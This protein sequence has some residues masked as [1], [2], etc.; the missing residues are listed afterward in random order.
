MLIA[1]WPG[2]TIENV[3]YTC[4]RRAF[5]TYE[6]HNAH[7]EWYVLE[8]RRRMDALI[9]AFFSDDQRALVNLRDVF[10]VTHLIVSAED[11]SRPPWYFAPFDSAINRAWRQGRERG[12]AVLR[13]LAQAAVW[14]DEKLTVLDL[15]KI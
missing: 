8:M 2:G 11:F 15:S 13:V 4:R 10:G 14:R 9:M 6:T 5:L 1:G 12:F 3:S 7:H